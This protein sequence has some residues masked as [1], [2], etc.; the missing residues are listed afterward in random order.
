MVILAEK[1]AFFFLSP[2]DL[3]TQIKTSENLEVEKKCFMFGS[4]PTLRLDVQGTQK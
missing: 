3:K 1:M 4:T 2:N